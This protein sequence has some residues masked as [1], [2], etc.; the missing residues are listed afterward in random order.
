MALSNA[1]RQKRYRFNQQ[2]K[3]LAGKEPSRT[4]LDVWLDHM[5]HH[6]LR[7][8]A[9]LHSTTLQEELERMIHASAVLAKKEKATWF[10]A[11]SAV[12]D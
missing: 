11:A 1:E 10:S 4:R 7:V 8:L 12:L 6:E 5:V 3:S 9:K 2:S